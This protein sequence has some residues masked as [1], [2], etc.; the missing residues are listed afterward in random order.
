MSAIQPTHPQSGSAPFELGPPG[1]LMPP[2]APET[3]APGLGDALRVVS[4]RKLT[5]IITFVVLYLLILGA[6]FVVRVYF[7]QYTSEALIEL[8]PPTMIGKQDPE[9]LMPDMMRQQLETEA[10]KLKQLALMFDVLK[11]PEI[12]QTQFY[13]WYEPDIAKAAF[14]LQKYLACAPIQ[15]ANL[16][17]VSLSVQD[18]KEAKLIVNTIVDRYRSKFVDQSKEEVYDRLQALKNSQGQLESRRDAL[19]KDMNRFRE[20][21]EMPAIEQE[22]GTTALAIAELQSQLTQYDATATSLQAQLDS[23]KDIPVNELPITPEMRLVIE[24][25]PI[26]RYY[27]S[28]VEGLDVTIASQR[29]TLGEGHRDVRRLNL[30][31]QGWSEK[32]ISKR[33]ELVNDIRERQIE[34]VRK[35]LASAQKIILRLQEQLQSEEAKQ[36]DL[37]RNAQR[38]SQ[39]RA[40]EELLLKE[41]EQI[42]TMVNQA[43][44]AYSDERTRSRRLTVVQHAEEAIKPSRPDYWVFL[45]GGAVAALLGAAGLA[46]L[47]EFTDKAIRTPIDVV[48]AGHLSVLGNVPQ[49]DEEQADLDSIEQATRQAPQSLVAEAFRQIRTNLLFSGPL[50]SQRSMLITSPAP[51]DGKTAVA[52]NLAVTLAQSNQRVLLIDCNFRRPAIREAFANTKREGL[53]N[54]LIGQGKLADFVTRTDVPNFDVLTSGPMPPTPA[55]LLG[56]TYMRDLIAEAVR[57]YDRVLLDGPPALLVSDAL[58]LATMVDGVVLVARAVN[59]TK[60]ALKRT[61]DQLERINARIIGAILNGVQARAGGYF[62]RQ[63]REFYE[64]ASEGTIPAELPEPPAEEPA[65]KKDA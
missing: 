58:V 65:D 19:R 61:R 59:N 55:D 29:M 54:I 41:I 64:Y 62:R 23:M 3:P 49:I 40:D 33:E 4:Q 46:F 11:Q 52:I 37:D 12:K 21:S 31:R 9:Q 51:G 60:G 25:D 57:T 53:S 39:M 48:R 56:S 14:E 30:T 42:N 35:D 10:R 18:R 38:Y 1:G 2:A 50:E 24:S 22:R 13:K 28:N 20:A 15:G 63:Y 26:L 34:A 17:R 7:P 44:H 47:R 27:R 45:G 43:E 5:I 6:T 36:R 8:E 16:I 32:E